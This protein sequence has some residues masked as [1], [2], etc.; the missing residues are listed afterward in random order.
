MRVSGP[1]HISTALSPERIDQG[2]PGRTVISPSSRTPQARGRGTVLGA[3]A[4]GGL[5]FVID[6]LVGGLFPKGP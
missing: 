2:V 4:G 5:G 1:E 6:A 3:V